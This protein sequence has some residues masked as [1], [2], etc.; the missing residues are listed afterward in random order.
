MPNFESNLFRESNKTK[1]STTDYLVTSMERKQSLFVMHGEAGGGFGEAR[2]KFPNAVI[3]GFQT[4][5]HFLLIQIAKKSQHR[6]LSAFLP[7]A[8]LLSH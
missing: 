3:L 6:D 8:V 4:G 7:P 5:F 1:R 2:E